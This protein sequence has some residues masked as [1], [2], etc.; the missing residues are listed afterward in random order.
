MK[1][2]NQ[3]RVVQV[4]HNAIVEGKK[5]HINKTLYMHYS[6]YYEIFAHLI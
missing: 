3:H 5:T 6:T 2:V 4:A 1:Y